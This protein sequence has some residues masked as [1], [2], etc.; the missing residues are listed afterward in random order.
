MKKYILTFLT[1]LSAILFVVACKKSSS[2]TPQNNNNSNNNTSPYYFKFSL[3]GI[4]YDFNANNPQF[5]TFYPD[6]A[7]G[8][9]TASSLPYPAIGLSFTWNHK[10]TV[11]ESDL[12]GLAGKT[13]Y[14][15]DTTITPALTFDSTTTSNT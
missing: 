15:S 13:L 6:L 5:I 14:F 12:L 2:T 8:Y 4:N 9:Q 11:L 7:G 10:D 1:L 3:N